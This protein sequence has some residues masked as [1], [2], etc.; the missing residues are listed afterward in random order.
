MNVCVA[1][2]AFGLAGCTA[3]GPGNGESTNSTAD[4]EATARAYS[5]CMSNA[6]IAVELQANTDGRLTQVMLDDVEW[7]YVVRLP[8]GRTIG[9]W[10]TDILIEQKALLTEADSGD[11][12]GLVIDGVDHTEQYLSCVAQ[13]GY[14]E[15]AA[16]GSSAYGQTD[17]AAVQ[18][19]VEANN[20]WAQCARQ[21]GLPEIQ[22]SAM[23]MTPTLFIPYNM[24]PGQ[25]QQLLE[26]C[27]NFDPEQHAIL[28]SWNSPYPPNYSPD[29]IITLDRTDLNGLSQTDIN[30]MKL[31]YDALGARAAEYQAEQ[32]THR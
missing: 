7:W 18:R 23:S 14:D 12:P 15:E 24:D 13:S 2:A 4:L 5:D 32:E 10:D 22:D 25:L 21:N 29:P 6:G 16:M 17:M 26:A 30:R 1:V 20:Q 19:Q 9:G 28:D 31:L 27:P 11:G 3:I 8:S